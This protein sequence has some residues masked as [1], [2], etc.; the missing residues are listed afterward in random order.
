MLITPAARGATNVGEKLHHFW[1][2]HPPTP[3]YPPTPPANPPPPRHARFFVLTRSPSPDEKSR[4]CFF[5]P[6]ELTGDSISKNPGHPRALE[7]LPA[8]GRKSI[9]DSSAATVKKE[10]TVQRALKCTQSTGAHSFPVSSSLPPPAPGQAP[11][12]DFQ[13]KPKPTT[14]S[15]SHLHFRDIDS[16]V[17]HRIDLSSRALPSYPPHLASDNVTNESTSIAA[18]RHASLTSRVSRSSPLAPDHA[19]IS[20]SRTASTSRQ[21]PRLLGSPPLTSRHVHVGT[22]SSAVPPGGTSP[23]LHELPS[24]AAAPSPPQQGL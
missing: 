11:E 16:N 22:L 10:Y 17:D 1:P 24:A 19:P 13:P 6:G 4:T 23:W 2:V 15:I 5:A 3:K 12:P 21:T 8:K 9:F 7:Q 14:P 20:S 18:P